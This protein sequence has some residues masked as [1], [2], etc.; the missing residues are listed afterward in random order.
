VFGLDP[1]KGVRRQLGAARSSHTSIYAISSIYA[2]CQLH[3]SFLGT[4]IADL[5]S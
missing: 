1:R 3:L 2:I 5:V 4:E